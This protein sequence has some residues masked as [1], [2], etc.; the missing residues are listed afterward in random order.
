M[1]APEWRETT[2]ALPTAGVRD[3]LSVT[4]V[5]FRGEFVQVLDSRDFQLPENQNLIVWLSALNDLRDSMED[6][7]I[8]YAEP[9]DGGTASD[10]SL[11]V[12]G[13]R[14]P[15]ELEREFLFPLLARLSK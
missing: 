12:T 9:F 4:P 8:S 7:T 6:A 5:R 10:I 11:V 13:W 3:D 2:V 1:G 15:D 14:A